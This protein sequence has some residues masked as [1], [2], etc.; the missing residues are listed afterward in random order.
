MATALGDRFNK[1]FTRKRTDA[2]AA[3]ASASGGGRSG[4]SR[5]KWRFKRPSPTASGEPV[6]VAAP[7]RADASREQ[8]VQ[9][10]KKGYNE[11][12]DT[13]Q[14]LR[15]HMQKQSERSDR[16]L[17]L[18]E[19]LPEVLKS[20]PETN[21]NQTQTLFA[22]REQFEQQ[23]AHSGELSSALNRLAQVTTQQDQREQRREESERESSEAMLGSLSTL[24]Q[25]LDGVREAQQSNA[26]TVDRIADRTEASQQTLGQVFRRGQRQ[27]TALA[28]VSWSLAL[29]AL[30]VSGFVAYEVSQLAETRRTT[31][32]QSQA[33]A[34]AASTAPTTQDPTAAPA[35]ADNIQAGPGV[36]VS[37]ETVPEQADQAEADTSAST[38]GEAT[39]ESANEATDESGGAETI[40]TA[41][42]SGQTQPAQNDAEADPRAAARW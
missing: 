20:I 4:P 35:D 13:M 31:M 34:S 42:A 38:G 30:A 15:D 33:P 36:N 11:V 19:G 24:N 28:A 14:V 39:D 3:T 16:L 40:E 25:T 6:E 21:R 9:Q 37:N 29:A 41:E 10:L 26:A 32:A 17:H 23:G 2:H 12:V 22:I 1:L 5:I 27:M 7:A 18:M 8:S